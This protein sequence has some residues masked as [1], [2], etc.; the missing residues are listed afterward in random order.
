MLTR[1]LTYA[2]L[3]LVVLQ[4]GIAMGDVHWL[5]E[6]GA[7]SVVIDERHQHLH[8]H[9]FSAHQDTLV[10]SEDE[11]STQ[12]DG[13]NCCQ[14]HGHACSAIMMAAYRVLITKCSSPVPDY[15]EC[16]LPDTFKTFLRPPK[17]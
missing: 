8:S 5:H 3:I 11:S 6:S 9:D 16:T 17:A 2:L 7:E 12:W 4:S 15:I 1:I 10:G 14:C 13:H